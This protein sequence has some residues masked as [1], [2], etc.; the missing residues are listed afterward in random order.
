M[1]SLLAL[2]TSRDD[3]L[4]A[5]T[6]VILVFPPKDGFLTPRV[7][8]GLIAFVKAFPQ[9]FAL[10]TSGGKQ[11]GNGKQQQAKA[12]ESKLFTSFFNLLKQ[13]I[14]DWLGV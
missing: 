1:N 4:P 12:P 14:A 7:W 13:G 5:M 3:I 6:A 8:S 9:V 10:E 2:L 11:Q